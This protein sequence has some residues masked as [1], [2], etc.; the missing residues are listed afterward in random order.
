ML[1][2]LLRGAA[3]GAAGATVLNAVTYLDMAV[4]GRPSSSTPEQLVETATD[5]V[6]GHGPRG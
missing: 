1:T 2:G 3:A 6:G 5:K 4:R